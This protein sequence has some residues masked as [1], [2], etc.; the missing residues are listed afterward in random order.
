[1]VARSPYGRAD[2]LLTDQWVCLAT[3]EGAWRSCTAQGN[4]ESRDRPHSLE[5]QLWK[6][7]IQWGKRM[8]SSV[9]RGQQFVGPAFGPCVSFHSPE[10]AA[11][12]STIRKMSF[13]HWPPQSQQKART[14]L[15]CTQRCAKRD[16]ICLLEWGLPGGCRPK[17]HGL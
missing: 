9:E 5:F 10:T 7:Q 16:A 4:T 12:R 17:Q 8:V 6:P 2:Y 1:M 11:I 14:G 13:G 15:Q 3:G